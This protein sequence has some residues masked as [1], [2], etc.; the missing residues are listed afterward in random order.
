MKHYGLELYFSFR[1][2]A[3]RTNINTVYETQTQLRVQEKIENKKHFYC[4]L[5]HKALRDTCQ[6]QSGVMMMLVCCNAVV[7]V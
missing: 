5:S 4:K 1:T 2:N 6:V 7:I 3:N